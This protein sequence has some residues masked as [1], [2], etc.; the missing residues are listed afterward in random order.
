MMIYTLSLLALVGLTALAWLLE[1][2]SR[3]RLDEAGAREEAEARLAGFRAAE[4][5]LADEGHGAVLR[6]VDGSIALLLPLG[7]GWIAR[8]LPASAFS[9]TG[10]RLEARLDEPMLKRA[11]LTLPARPCWLAA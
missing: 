9:W 5:V 8:R 3:P 10:A 11:A 6:G 2:R 1:F 4:L 7:D